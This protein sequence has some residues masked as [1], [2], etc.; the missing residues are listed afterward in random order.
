VTL[1]WSDEAGDHSVELPVLRPSSELGNPVIDV[2]SLA[3]KTGFF[4]HDPGFTS[5]SSC[6]SA[7]S[8]IDGDKGLLMHRGYA[9]EDLAL[10]CSFPGALWAQGRG[11]WGI[12]WIGRFRL[13]TA[14]GAAHAPWVCDRAVGMRSKISRSITPF[15]VH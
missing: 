6:E 3:S 12:K 5:T 9:I 10:N 11:A 14:I 1:S 8:F 13:S 7:I 2:Q 15:Q 4:T